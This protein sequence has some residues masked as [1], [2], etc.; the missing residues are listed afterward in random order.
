MELL[1]LESLHQGND[2][3]V[4]QEHRQ[5]DQGNNGTLYIAHSAQDDVQVYIESQIQEIS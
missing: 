1:V 2:F 3:L 4:G 5:E